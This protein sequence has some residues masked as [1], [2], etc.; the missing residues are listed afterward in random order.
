MDKYLLKYIRDISKEE[1][2]KKYIDFLKVDLDGF[3]YANGGDINANYGALRTIDLKFY[4][5]FIKNIV[6]SENAQKWL[7]RERNILSFVPLPLSLEKDCNI[8][9]IGSFLQPM[10]TPIIKNLETIK[11]KWILSH[12]ITKRKFNEIVT[13][14]TATLLEEYN[15][16]LVNCYSK[17]NF[18]ALFVSHGEPFLYKYHID[19]FKKLKRPSFIFLHGLPA[20]YNLETEKNSDYLLVWG[21]KI[22]E[23]YINAGF[24]VDRI[25]VTGHHRFKS[26][27]VIGKLRNSFDDVLVATT[28]SNVW[29]PH[30]W[31]Y[32]TFPIY[33]SSL[34]V[35]Y[36]YSVQ[37]VLQQLGINHARLRLHPSVNRKWMKSFI[38]NDFYTLDTLSLSESLNKATL[39]IGPTSTICLEAMFAGVNYVVYELGENKHDIHNFPLVPPFDG[40]DD[41]LVVANTEEDLLYALKNKF[42]NSSNLLDGYLR[43]FDFEAINNVL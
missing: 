16:K 32:G 5:S 23:N 2:V 20:I 42:L 43:P 22:K 26:I 39:V 31:D 12:L 6:L 40:S 28:A 33:D 29:S 9:L 36:C 8:S 25:I 34:I 10:N 30:D 4:L 1:L 19:I 38:D 7:S 37:N 14:Q 24:N 17:Y 18:R 13:Y 35:L 41:N 15:E 21:D 3:F 11:L 27:P